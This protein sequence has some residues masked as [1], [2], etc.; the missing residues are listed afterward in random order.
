MRLGYRG[1]DCPETELSGGGMETG[2]I[3]LF[4]AT[5]CAVMIP[6]T[7]CLLPKRYFRTQTIRPRSNAAW[8]GNCDFGYSECLRELAWQ[9]CAPFSSCGWGFRQRAVASSPL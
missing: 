5:E 8:L 6:S 1:K 9:P 3:V 2:G 4:S 7:A